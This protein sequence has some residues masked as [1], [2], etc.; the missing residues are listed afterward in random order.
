MS[1]NEP[2]ETPINSQPFEFLV[3][4]KVRAVTHR[5]SLGFELRSGYSRLVLDL[6]RDVGTEDADPKRLWLIP[7]GPPYEAETAAV[8]KGSRLLAEF[9]HL[10]TDLS[11]EAVRQFA[12]RYGWLTSPIAVRRQST[13]RTT[14]LPPTPNAPA[15]VITAGGEIWADSLDDWIAAVLRLKALRRL[16]HA[17]VAMETPTPS[18]L[19]TGSAKKI[20]NAAIARSR[21]GLS[22]LMQA[23]S[24][25]SSLDEVRHVDNARVLRLIPERDIAGAATYAVC[26]EINESLKGQ[27]DTTL[28]PFLSREVRQ[29]PRTLLATVFLQFAV[30]VAGGTEWR[31]C[32]FEGCVATFPGPR[33][34]KYCIPE[35]KNA[36]A[37]LQRVRTA[38]AKT[39]DIAGNDVATPTIRT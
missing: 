36:Q 23:E 22:Y 7:I 27:V 11:E 6:W 3:S 17:V 10:A 38:N 21:M 1:T 26:H 20:L 2:N 18:S 35:H 12:S 9:D 37:Y 24:N 14:A 15:R 5:P 25:G 39:P 34:R 4:G 19:A 33:N 13:V 31:S 16:W 28:L 29:I 30:E 8:P 32:Q